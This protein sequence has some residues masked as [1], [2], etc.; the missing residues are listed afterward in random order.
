M[1]YLSYAKIVPLETFVIVLSSMTFILMCVMNVS[2]IISYCRNAGNPYLTDKNKKY[3]RHYKRVIVAWNLGYVV[4]F[5]MSNTGFSVVDFSDKGD[6][7]KS[8]Q[9]GFWYSAGLFLTIM[10]GEIIPFYLAIGGK[11][12]KISTLKFL[13]NT[14]TEAEGD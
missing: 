11:F 14:E 8:T 12:T 2:A 4:K 1:M 10:F 9:D 7:T 5:T 3:V 13:E 6:P